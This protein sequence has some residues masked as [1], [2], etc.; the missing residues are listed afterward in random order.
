MRVRVKRVEGRKLLVGNGGSKSK[1]KGWMSTVFKHLQ[2]DINILPILKQVAEN[3]NDFN[4][5]TRRQKEYVPVRETMTIHLIKDV[6]FDKFHLGWDENTHETIRAEVYH[7]YNECV[8]FLNWFEK[9][10]GGIIKRVSIAHLPA[11]GKV[12]PH[13]DYAVASWRLPGDNKDRFHLV[14]SGYYDYTVGDETRR[15]GAG[16]LFWFDNKKIH[17]SINATPIPRIS[18]IF[19]VEG[20]TI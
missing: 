8:Y 18:L 13:T 12:Y 17:S 3:W 1:G 11:G 10:Y 5:D 19:D 6:I 14:L 4:L 20:C 15:F 9:M 7:K 2:S 16:D